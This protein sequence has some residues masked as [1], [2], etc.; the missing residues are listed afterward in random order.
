MFLAVTCPKPSP[1]EKGEAR[2]ASAI[3]TNSRGD[4]TF[5][6]MLVYRCDDGFMLVGEKDFAICTADGTWDTTPPHCV[7]FCR[8]PGAFE[9][10]VDLEE[11]V[12]SRSSNKRCE[13]VAGEDV[14]R[15]RRSCHLRLSI[16]CISSGG[17]ERAWVHHEWL[18]APITT[19]SAMTKNTTTVRY[20]HVVFAHICNQ[21]SLINLFF[22]C[23]CRDAYNLHI[24]CSLVEHERRVNKKPRHLRLGPLW[25][26]DHVCRVRGRFRFKFPVN[27]VGG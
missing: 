5:G 18:V 8:Y 14:L 9:I 4:F 2:V 24:E 26:K 1:P 20:I 17:R 10:W 27:C 22:N 16:A 23:N 3:D 15:G 25:I 13:H 11:I 21:R 7:K 19:M 6:K 12:N